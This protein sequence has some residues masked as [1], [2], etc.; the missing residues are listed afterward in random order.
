MSKKIDRSKSRVCGRCGV[1][2]QPEEFGPSKAGVCRQCL[3]EHNRAY[4]EKRTGRKV[5]PL[6]SWIGDYKVCTKCGESKHRTEYGMQSKGN[7]EYRFFSLCKQCHNARQRKR[8]AERPE[9]QK[10]LTDDAM[11]RYAENR[12]EVRSGRLYKQY[13]ITSEDKE[14][15]LA[16][17]GGKCPI[18]G[19]TDPGRYWVVDH[20]HRDQIVR[21]LLCDSCNKGLGFFK[22]NPK[23]LQA[24]IW[25]L[26]ESGRNKNQEAIVSEGVPIPEEE[27]EFEYELA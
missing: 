18:C 9:V 26:L 12:N 16:D 8:Y 14:R 23:S 1:F 10:K 25:Y 2:K 27:L 21:G 19:T 15:M 6:I 3:R 24:A 17:N 7:G 5:K 11:N 22:D 20:C 13:G 4:T